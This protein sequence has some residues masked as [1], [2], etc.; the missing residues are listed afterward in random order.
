MELGGRRQPAWRRG[1]AGQSELV[2]EGIPSLLDKIR[3]DGAV[4][5]EQ[6]VGEFETIKAHP[7]SCLLTW[8]S[9]GFASE[10][11]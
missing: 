11:L 6:S 9:K 5:L 2:G 4:H 10:G 7:D 1:L 3:E 8:D